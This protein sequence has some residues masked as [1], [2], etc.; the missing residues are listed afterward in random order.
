MWRSPEVYKAQCE[1]LG[2]AS[3]PSLSPQ[4]DIYK[5]RGELQRRYLY[6]KPYGTNWHTNWTDYCIPS[7]PASNLLKSACLLISHYSH[8]YRRT[9]SPYRYM[10]TVANFKGTWCCDSIAYQNS[11]SLSLLPTLSPVYSKKTKHQKENN[12][13]FELSH[14]I[15]N[16]IFPFNISTLKERVIILITKKKKKRWYLRWRCHY[17]HTQPGPRWDIWAQEHNQTTFLIAITLTVYL[18][19]SESPL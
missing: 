14:W 15:S 6:P 3:G 10:A 19:C 2:R 9:D 12:N 7:T 11:E 13:W 5:R 18:T 8:R 16:W 17:N 1:C 4:A